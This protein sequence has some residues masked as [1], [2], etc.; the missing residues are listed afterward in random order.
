[1]ATIIA[2]H[3]KFTTK[4]DAEMKYVHAHPHYEIYYLTSGDRH[5]FIEDNVYRVVSGD[6][7]LISPGQIHKTSGAR[8]ECIHIYF[9]SE[10][11]NDEILYLAEE[12]FSSKVIK[13][14]PTDRNKIET[15]LLDICHEYDNSQKTSF[16]LMK[17]MLTTLFVYLYRF[18]SIKVAAEENS[19]ENY[20]KI[21]DVVTYINTNYS[22]ELVVPELCKMSY[23][24]HS[25]FCKKFREIVGMPA[26]KYIN[27]IRVNEAAKLL[28]STNFPI[29]EI[30]SMVG[31]TGSNYF[32]DT[33]KKYKGISPK[34]YRKSIKDT[35][36]L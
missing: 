5:Y 18:S 10:V 22:Q 1:M 28:T 16:I 14:P 31:F 33:F 3:S 7:A 6:F 23:L 13:V 2:K 11:L 20:N 27:C 32:G 26:S 24:S 12:C 34:Q 17:T 36:G 25:Y 19:D 21:L 35:E 30:A 29:T 15:L 8:M 4:E 9:D